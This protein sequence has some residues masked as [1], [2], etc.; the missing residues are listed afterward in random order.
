MLWEQFEVLGAEKVY[1]MTINDLNLITLIGTVDII[2][3]GE[4]AEEF[5]VS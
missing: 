4:L 5:F 3:E 2:F 1:K